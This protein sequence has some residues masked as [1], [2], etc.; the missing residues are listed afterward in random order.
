MK[1]KTL[2]CL[3]MLV[4]FSA[5]LTAQTPSA[6]I[7]TQSNNL[8]GAVVRDFDNRYEGVR[9]TPM[10]FES[11]KEAVI[12]FRDGNKQKIPVNLDLYNREILIKQRNSNDMMYLDKKY[13]TSVT[14][15][16]PSVGAAI[17]YAMFPLA[18]KI[19]FFQTLVADT[20]GLYLRPRK[21]LE[22]ADFNGQ[23]A[24]AYNTGKRYDE[25]VD[26]NTY[27]I[28]TRNGEMTEVKPTKAAV[29]K[30]FPQ[31]E[32]VIEKYIKSNKLNLKDQQDLI[33]VI[34]YINTL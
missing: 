19:D 13:I 21:I 6:G 20:V 22:K 16:D 5:R 25:F 18:G 17:V 8:T 7:D 12:Q 15:G 24:G 32:A 9:G 27:F 2:L 31:Q 28:R 4:S 1:I 26:A 23:T 34:Q 33:T 14:F 29:L 11:L 3:S 10:L 30:V